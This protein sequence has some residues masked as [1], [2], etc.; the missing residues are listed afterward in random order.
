MRSAG[1]TVRVVPRTPR[2]ERPVSW[3]TESSTHRR[4]PFRVWRPLG[5]WATLAAP[6]RPTIADGLHCPVSERMWSGTPF[7]V[8]SSVRSARTSSDLTFFAALIA[9]YSLLN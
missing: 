7:S 2:V 6:T 3:Q 1:S 8:K 9:K 5:E 4:P